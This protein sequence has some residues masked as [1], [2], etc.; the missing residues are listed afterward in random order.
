MIDSSDRNVI[1]RL[2]P[3]DE[4]LDLLKWSYCQSKLD[5]QPF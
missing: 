2:S 3:L 4:H 1:S 5:I